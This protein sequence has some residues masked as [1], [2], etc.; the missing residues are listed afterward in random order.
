[1]ILSFRRSNWTHFVRKICFCSN[2]LQRKLIL[3]SW[4]HV[5]SL[6]S[7]NFL[8][9]ILLDKIMNEH[10]S[11]TYSHNQLI[12]FSNFNVNSFL[13]KLINTLRFSKEKNFH[14]LSFWECVY[15]VSKNNIYFIF[16]VTNINSLHFCELLILF[17]QL[18]NFGLSLVK[19]SLSLVKLLF[20]NFELFQKV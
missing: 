2:I 16:S 14:F 17:K 19:L 10:I 8:V 11:S 5:F 15:K 3:K 12:A 6:N 20:K 18:L 13:S 9:G 1:M 4:N 7:F